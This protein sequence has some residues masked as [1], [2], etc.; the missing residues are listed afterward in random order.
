MTYSS[1][2]AYLY[3]LQ[4]HG[5]KLGLETMT[6]L[7]VRLG[8]PQ[9]KYRTLHIAGTNGKGSTAAMA[10]TVLQ[11][12]GYRVGL[13][14]SPHL[15]EF[16]ERIRVNGEMIAESQVAQLTEQ[17]QTLCEPD[18]SPTFFE[19][20]TA[21]A[22]Q[23]F[24][25]S[26]VDVAVLEVGLGGRF[27]AT[28]VVMPMACAVTT[29]SL[30]HQEYLGPTLSSIAFEKAG[31]IKPGVP[32]VLGRLEDDAWRA[33]EQVARKQ[34]APA[35]RLNEDFRTEG[36]GPQQFSYRGLGM[37]YDGLTCALEGRH[38]LDN[39]ACALA[40]LE[41][42]APQGIAVTAEAVTAA[43]RAVNWAGRLEVVDRRPTILLDGAHNPAAAT[44][45]ADYLTRS[46]QSHPSR[47][48]VLVLGMMRDKD[49]RGFVEPLRSLIDE[50][51]LT[52]A[53]LPR[54]ATAH[55]LRASLEGLLSH[56]HVVP[57]FSDAM[58]LARKLA[59]PDGLVCVTGSL[60][61]VGECQ[62]WV[63]GV[64]LSPLRG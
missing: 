54:S 5:I 20:T 18:L 7:T 46:D 29:I 48:V 8:K 58:A 22:F 14:T 15:V 28:N 11:A 36:E 25:D 45:L 6:A 40:L 9:T 47:P 19:Y 53:D 61:L 12:A 17:L 4:R 34:Q 60:M 10:A 23:H 57:S 38:Q 39:A 2:V 31:I 59:T 42:A 16:R 55:E 43:L 37:Q 50:V 56:P 27:D 32:V 49:H 44:A 26:G 63:R 62:A 33:I 30:D 35:F 13:Y 21:M 1:A 24:A 52:Q 64:G 3:R 51:V 41:A